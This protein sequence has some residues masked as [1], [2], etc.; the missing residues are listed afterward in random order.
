MNTWKDEI[1][2]II[3]NGGIDQKNSKA[4]SN[5]KKA[6]NYFERW[7]INDEKQKTMN[8]FLHMNS[9]LEFSEISIEKYNHTWYFLSNSN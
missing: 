2:K 7:D 4:D 6:I 5:L 3:A 8:H 1:E 9:S